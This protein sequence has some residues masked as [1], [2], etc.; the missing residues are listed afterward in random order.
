M[1][2]FK[3]GSNFMQ[4]PAEIYVKLLPDGESVRLTN[5]NVP[6]LGPVFTPDGSRIAY[7]QVVA[8]DWET[9][10]VPVQGGQPTRLLPNAAGV[11]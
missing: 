5:D 8:G 7:T 11:S 4:G 1:L 9:W 10:T 3:S 6:K 2:T